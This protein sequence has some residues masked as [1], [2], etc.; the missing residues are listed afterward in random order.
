MP[1]SADRRAVLL[2]PVMVAMDQNMVA[3]VDG[4]NLTMV[5]RTGLRIYN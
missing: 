5:A 2:K 3:E 1:Y 4:V